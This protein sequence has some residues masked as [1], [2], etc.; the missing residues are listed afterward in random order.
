MGDGCST[1][2]D[3]AFRDP[4]PDQPLHGRIVTIPITVSEPL[5]TNSF[6]VEDLDI[7][8]VDPS[9]TTLVDSGSNAYSLS[10][11]PHSADALSPNQVSVTLPAGQIT[12][13]NGNSSVYD[14]SRAYYVAP[15]TL[16]PTEQAFENVSPDLVDQRI[17]FGNE[18]LPSG[19]TITWSSTHPVS[20]NMTFQTLNSEASRFLASFSPDISS[21]ELEVTWPSDVFQDSYGNRSASFTES[22]QIDYVVPTAT[23]DSLPEGMVTGLEYAV[24]VALSEPL[25]RDIVSSD[26]E[27]EPVNAADVLSVDKVSATQYT[28]NF[29]ARNATES[30]DLSIKET[31]LQ[32]T[33]STATN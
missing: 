7:S 20:T 13:A 12:D 30:F 9:Q 2:T 8:G 4:T 16:V 31:T 26:I 5:E 18:I 25:S 3:S 1:T 10:L 32:D 29:V 15:H 27:V 33:S 22:I 17:V 28:V 24:G 11:V 21:G 14:F 19:A 23:F 6:V